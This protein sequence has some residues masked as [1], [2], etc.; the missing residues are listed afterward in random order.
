M[1]QRIIDIFEQ[2]RKIYDVLGEVY[3]EKAYR[4]AITSIKKLNYEITKDRLPDTKDNKIAGVGVG[5]INKITEI[6]NH[7]RAAELDE[8]RADPK[9]RAFETFSNTIGFGPAFIRH[10]VSKKIYDHVTLRRAL[11]KRKIELTNAQK[12]GVM[13]YDDLIKRIPRAEVEKLGNYFINLVRRE[14]PA[15]IAQI[16]GSYRRE[17]STSGDVDIICV[18]KTDVDNSEKN[19]YNDP[20]YINTISRGPQRVTFL[21]CSKYGDTLTARQIDIL[22]VPPESYAAALLYFTGSANFNQMMR[23]VAQKMGYRLN[24]IGLYK[25]HNGNAQNKLQLI[26]TKTERDIFAELSMTYVEPRDRH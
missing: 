19:L 4:T 7:G 11:A 25:V 1:N 20:C 21:Y 9:V 23:A 22:W 2:L 13:Y 8:L 5:L 24:Q 16:V 18:A 6:V 15:A 3:K 17:L 14:D 12:L 26:P 10:L